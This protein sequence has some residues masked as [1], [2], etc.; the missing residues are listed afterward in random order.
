MAA[1]DST[2]PEIPPRIK[3]AIKTLDAISDWSGH[4][5]AWLVIPLMAVLVFEVISRYV[6]DKPTLWAFDFTYMLY[7]AHF[8]LVS[9][10]TLFKQGHIRTDFLYRT[11]SPKWQGIVDATLYLVLF[12]PAVSFFFWF[13]L[14][15][16]YESWIQRETSFLS[17]W[18]PPIYP[19]KIALPMSAFLLFLQGIAEFLRSLYAAKHGR[20]HDL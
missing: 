5:V 4:V 17:P 12:L 3:R 11:W 7:G 15:F 18:Q 2:A 20:W 9:A 13:S 8:M 14:E 1:Y 10:F 6:F 19:L 16:A